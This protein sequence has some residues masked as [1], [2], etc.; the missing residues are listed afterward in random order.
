MNDYKLLEKNFFAIILFLLP[1]LQVYLKSTAQ[2]LLYV[3]FLHCYQISDTNND[4]VAGMFDIES[5]RVTISHFL[6]Q[7]EV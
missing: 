1:P 6:S 7:Q 2:N 4:V 5:N 3:W